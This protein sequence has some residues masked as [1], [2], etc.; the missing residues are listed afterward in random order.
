MCLTSSTRTEIGVDSRLLMVG[1]Q[2]ANLTPG[3]S[4]GHNLC[5][6]CPNGQH[7][8]I[9]DIY[10]P[11]ALHWYKKFLK[12]LSFDPWNCPL[13]IW[14]SIRTLTPKAKL[15][16]GVR[17]HSL[18]PSHTSE[19]MLCDSRLLSWPATLQTLALVAS[20]RQDCDNDLKEKN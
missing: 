7:E 20:P 9:L 19:S 11:R 5:F 16:W 12:P 15:P 17:V 8:P 2:T 18:T 10:V 3:L 6:K 14:D 1:N 4:F 13:K